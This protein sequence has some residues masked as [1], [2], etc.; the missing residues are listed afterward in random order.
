MRLQ[1]LLQTRRDRKSRP[2]WIV[3]ATPLQLSESMLYTHHRDDLV[4]GR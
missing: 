2:P 4:L 1:L 3:G